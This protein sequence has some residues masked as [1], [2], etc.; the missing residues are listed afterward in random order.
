MPKNNLFSARIAKVGLSGGMAGRR[1]GMEYTALPFCILSA[2]ISGDKDKN[3]FLAERCYS[4]I[5][6]SISERR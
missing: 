3:Y 2:K 1:T 6:F 4:L 5:Y